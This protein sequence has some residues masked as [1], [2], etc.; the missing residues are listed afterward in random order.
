MK[1]LG[2][3]DGVAAG[4]AVL[5]SGRILA[6]VNEERLNRKKMALGFPELSIDEVLRLSGL[7]PRDVDH[8]AVATHDEYFRMPAILWNGWFQG[9]RGWLKEIQLTLG[10]WVVRFLGASR[11]FQQVYYWFRLPGSTQ[12][13][14]AIRK[15][16]KERWGFTCPVTFTEHHDSHAAAAYYTS[17]LRDAT[18]ISLDGGGDGRSAKVFAARDGRLKELWAV[19]AYDSIGNYYAY[20]TH[21]CGF[22][23]H[24]HEGKITGLAAYG[25][26][27]YQP[28]LAGLIDCHDGTIKNKSRSFFLSSLKRIR[29]VL[30]PDFKKEDLAAS[31]Q[32]HLEDACV[33][34][35]RHW[36][37][38]TGLGDLAI[39]GGVVANVKLN[40]R[41]GEIPEV[42][43]LYVFP[44]MS[45]E[46]LAVG[47]AYWLLAQQR[48]EELARQEPYRPMQMFFG[49]GFTDE[50]IEKTLAEH[51][52]EYERVGDI[53]RR[54]AELLSRGYVVARFAGPMEYGPRSLGNR[55]ILYQPTDPT[56]ND[57]LNKRLVR[58]EFMPFA[59]V[60]LKEYA[61]QCYKDMNGTAH[62]A[63]F[64]TVT[65]DCTDWMKKHC[66]AV[67]HVDGTARP[68]L[69]DKDLEPSYYRILDEY[70]RITGLPCLINTS[71]NMHEE[72]IVCTPYDA[73]RAFQL[74]HL[75]YLAIGHFLVEN[76]IVKKG[77]TQRPAEGEEA[78]LEMSHA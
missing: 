35:V 26:P 56:V 71:F 21:I 5:R 30:P 64:M 67:V 74:G 62:A 47:A 25:K 60:T 70:R 72:P 68:Q 23:A 16:L 1:I 46:G 61:D 40:Q 24:K 41:L 75:D 52:V 50:E 20:I 59:P 58:T 3:T 11:L 45:D 8:I 4:A 44:A 51:D 15:V 10:S 63:R 78:A 31:M 17:G 29:E 43:S 38:K 14:R 28:D 69:I 73:L 54:V 76:E 22:K 19:S 53:E 65:A 12:R 32:Q 6:A 34:F 33:R 7:T 39:A 18:V 57:W 37:Q 48:P 36:V 77:R 55:S 2:I 49:P 13:K 42:R 9:D 27:V 66:P